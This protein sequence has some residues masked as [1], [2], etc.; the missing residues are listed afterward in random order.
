MYSATKH[1]VTALTEGLRRELVNLKSKIRVTVSINLKRIFIFNL[2]LLNSGYVTYFRIC[3]DAI[4][5]SQ[6]TSLAGY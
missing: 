6:P 3:N 1:A 4:W 2:I 5:V